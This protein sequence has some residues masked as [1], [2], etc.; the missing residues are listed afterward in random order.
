MKNLFAFFYGIRILSLKRRKGE[1]TRPKML[2]SIVSIALSLIPVIVII[3]VTDGMIE[4]ITSRIIEFSSGHLQSGVDFETEADLLSKE[5]DILSGIPEVT[6]AYLER[7]GLGL[8]FHNNN[9]SVISVRAVPRDLYEIDPGFARYVKCSEGTFSLEKRNQVVIGEALA[10]EFSIKVGDTIRVYTFRGGFVPGM[11]ASLP[12]VTRLSVSGIYSVGYREL[13]KN[14]LFVSYQDGS[15]MLPFKNSTTTYKIKVRDP[16]MDLN[17][18]SLEIEQLIE[19]KGAFLRTTPWT[20]INRNHYSAYQTTKWLL[21]FITII[22]V[23]VA[24][25]NIMSSMIMVVLDRMHEIGILK[26]IGA[27]PGSI[28]LSFVIVGFCT[29][30]CGTVLGVGAGLFVAV[31]INAV[32]SGIEIIANAVMTAINWIS[33][34]FSGSFQSQQIQILNP[35]YYLEKIPIRIEV[36]E[37]SIVCVFTLLVSMLFSYFPARMAAKIRPLE[38]IRKH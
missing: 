34:I 36:W 24:T 35:E 28:M 14:V 18:L 38:V 10:A 22:I 20:Y 29:G 33:S 2:I 27:K 7:E 13:D 25:F 1:K 17:A 37:V 31:N 4:G 6:S 16:F 8:L 15:L 30:L 19:A 26:G 21:V 9:R 11:S 23:L 3:V 5:K 12:R 32:I